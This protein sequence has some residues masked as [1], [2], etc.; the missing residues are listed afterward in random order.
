MDKNAL[1]KGL[2]QLSE[3]NQGLVYLGGGFRR[4]DPKF[5][6]YTGKRLPPRYSEAELKVYG[7]RARFLHELI[8]AAPK[9]VALLEA[10]ALPPEPSDPS[11]RAPTREDGQARDDQN[12][13]RS[14]I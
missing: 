10:M 3:P 14:G 9:V 5:D 6:A 12:E 7:E 1:L 4:G 2:R 13:P 11:G 8:H